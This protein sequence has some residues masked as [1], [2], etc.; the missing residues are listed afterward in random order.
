MS[1]N[2]FGRDDFW[3]EQSYKYLGQRDLIS[4]FT[5]KVEGHFRL[6]IKLD[7]FNLMLERK[8]KKFRSRDFESF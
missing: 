8:R 6:Q 1:R 5:W 2:N 4:I 3:S 7:D